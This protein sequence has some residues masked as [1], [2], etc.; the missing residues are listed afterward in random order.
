[1]RYPVLWDAVKTTWH[2]EESEY[3]TL[4][5]LLAQHANYILVNQFR[6]ELGLGE[7]DWGSPARTSERS[8]GHHVPV[9]IGGRIVTGAEID[10]DPLVYAIGANLTT[11]GAFTAVI[12]REH[13]PYIKLEFA[14][15]R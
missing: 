5:H 11:G 14:L 15:R 1:M 9:T 12:A 13:L 10:T 4:E 6:D 7:H 8:V 2:R 3:T